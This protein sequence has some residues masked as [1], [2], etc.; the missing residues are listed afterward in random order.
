M[1][2]IS[3]GNKARINGEKMKNLAKK[4]DVSINTIYRII[5]YKNWNDKFRKEGSL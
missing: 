2:V 4:Y 3:L 5:S 1:R